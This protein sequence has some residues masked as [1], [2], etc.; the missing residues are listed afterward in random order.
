MAQWELVDALSYEV[1]LGFQR[2][3]EEFE[4]LVS[5]FRNCIDTSNTF[6]T[7]KLLSSSKLLVISSLFPELESK[8]RVT[9]TL[10]LEKQLRILREKMETL[11]EQADKLHELTRNSFELFQQ[12]ITE[13][14][15]N[16]LL[17]G[18]VD[19][20]S[21][22]EYLTNLDYISRLVRLQVSQLEEICFNSQLFKDR[23]FI[24]SKD[25]LDFETFVEQS[26][27]KRS[28]VKDWFLKLC[29][30]RETRKSLER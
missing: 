2:W 11:K 3:E 5:I 27:L 25:S 24:V 29:R 1:Q 26:S 21:P 20:V 19:Q 18:R 17:T 12:V 10:Q 16:F 6:R 22:L 30:L 15:S 23:D 14:K 4:H 9:Q 7:L 13:D 28:E 8:L